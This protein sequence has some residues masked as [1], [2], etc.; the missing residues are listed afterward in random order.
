MLN[1]VTQ[2]NFEDKFQLVQ[3]KAKDTA[4]CAHCALMQ[5]TEYVY[6]RNTK[7]YKLLTYFFHL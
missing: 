2:R 1:D 7:C 6:L 3:S 4:Q 5:T